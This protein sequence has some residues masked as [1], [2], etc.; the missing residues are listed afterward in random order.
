MAGLPVRLSDTAGLRVAKSD[1]EAEGVKRARQRALD[2]DI[3]IF[4]QDGSSEAWDSQALSLLSEVDFCV[5]NKSDLPLH[6]AFPAAPCPITR[7]SAL[8]GDG[9]TEFRDQLE[10]RI[11]ELFSPSQSAGL[12]RA[13]H[14]DCV[15]RAKDSLSRALDNLG[16]APELSGDDIRRALHAIKE[17]AGETDIERVFDRIFSR[18]CVGK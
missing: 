13:R 7:L 9:L 17:L 16:V 15:M 2:S 6:A 3:R 5:I 14:R 1:I 12:T 10:A 18:F 4:V 8:T 11:V